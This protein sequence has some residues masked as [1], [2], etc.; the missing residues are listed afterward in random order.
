M[1]R[2]AR[3]EFSNTDRF[4]DQLTEQRTYIENTAVSGQARE[5]SLYVQSSHADDAGHPDAMH[6][7]GGNPDGELRR[8]NPEAVS[9]GYFHDAANREHDL[10]GVM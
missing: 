2:V 3:A 10:I 9:G 6:R 7:A 1:E 5:A 8:H 4:D